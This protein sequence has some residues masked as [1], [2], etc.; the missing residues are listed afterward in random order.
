MKVSKGLEFH[1][2]ALPGVRHMPAK[3]E[4]ETEAAR[5]L[6]SEDVGYA[7][8]GDWGGWRKLQTEPGPRQL[9]SPQCQSNQRQP[10]PAMFTCL[11]TIQQAVLM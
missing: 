7:A 8:V 2:V 1:V 4:D 6:C 5:V 11:V 9:S 10:E 3:G